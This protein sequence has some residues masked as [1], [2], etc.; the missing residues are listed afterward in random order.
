[1]VQ[2]RTPGQLDMTGNRLSPRRGGAEE[3]LELRRSGDGVRLERRTTGAANVR[4]LAATA[5][6]GSG[7]E[8]GATRCDAERRRCGAGA[9]EKPELLRSDDGVRWAVS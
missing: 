1:M 8:A 4:Y 2:K 5:W 7:G 3:K 6:G 9:E